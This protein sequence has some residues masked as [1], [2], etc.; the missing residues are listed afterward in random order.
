MELFINYA[1][2]NQGNQNIFALVTAG[3]RVAVSGNQSNQGNH[4]NNIVE[5]DF[6]NKAAIVFNYRTTEN[7][8]ALL[9]MVTWGKSLEEARHILNNRYGDR[10]LSVEPTQ[11]KQEIL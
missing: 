7:P 4:K 10:L 2:G 6:Q 11:P 9:T 5:V 8:S 3:N 1:K